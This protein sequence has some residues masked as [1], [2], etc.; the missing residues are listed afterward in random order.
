MKSTNFAILIYIHGRNSRTIRSRP[1]TWSKL[2]LSSTKT[3][4]WASATAKEIT[5]TLEYITAADTWMKRVYDV[6]DLLLQ[7]LMTQCLIISEKDLIYILD[8]TTP[9]CKCRCR[10]GILV[11]Y[12]STNEGTAQLIL[13]SSVFSPT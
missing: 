1:H 7:P 11:V 13:S 6:T 3:L 8:G 5:R 12:H 9:T 2:L 4:P 10:R